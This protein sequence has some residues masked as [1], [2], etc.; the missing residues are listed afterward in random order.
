MCYTRHCIPLQSRRQKCSEEIEFLVLVIWN[1][2]V[3]N[4]VMVTSIKNK[5]KHL[6]YLIQMCKPAYICL[7]HNNYFLA[8]GW[9][10]FSFLPHHQGSNMDKWH[11]ERQQRCSV[12][13][14]VAVGHPS[15][16]HTH[17]PHPVENWKNL[18]I[19]Q[20]WSLDLKCAKHYYFW[21]NWLIWTVYQRKQSTKL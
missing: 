14:L 8:V 1:L 3:H 10:V 13:L 21:S 5:I 20:K 9:S 11:L 19:R 2:S 12:Q 6:I 7:C 16:C 17:Q 18:S 15:L 4:T